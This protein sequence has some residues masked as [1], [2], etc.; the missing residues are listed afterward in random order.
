MYDKFSET[1]QRLPWREALQWFDTPQKR[2]GS[3][4]ATTLLLLT[5]FPLIDLISLLV[6][7]GS[8]AGVLALWKPWNRRRRQP[9]YASSKVVDLQTYRQKR[10]QPAE[11]PETLGMQVVLET[12]FVPQA[13]LI[14]A[15][16]ESRG[17]AARV[18][19][20]HNASILVHPL[21][22]LSVQV[23]V[24]AADVN[25]ALR[26]IEQEARHPSPDGPDIA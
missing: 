13:D 16:F 23:V 14:C 2:W 22:S 19:N 8:L 7:A 1:A 10:T 17:I 9:A 5:L 21:G 6:V 24:P 4:L 15:L 12:T 3:A 25:R 20:R 11:E 26:L 18:L